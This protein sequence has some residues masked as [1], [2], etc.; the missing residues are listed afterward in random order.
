MVDKESDSYFFVQLPAHQLTWLESLDGHRRGVVPDSLPHLS[1]LAM[2]EFLEEL[3]AVPVNLPLVPR[4]VTQVRRDRLLDLDRRL[5]F[6]Y[7]LTKF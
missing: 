7:E 3:E 4:V 1:E 5:T 6:K 2:A